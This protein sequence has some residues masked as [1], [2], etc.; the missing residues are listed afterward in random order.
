MDAFR[1]ISGI[2]VPMI[3]DNIDTDIIFPARFLLIMERKGLGRYLFYDRRFTRS[4]EPRGDSIIDA[5][6]YAG[7]QILIAGA[8]F[9]C[10]SSREQAVWALAGFGIRAVIAPG[11]GEIFFANCFM[12]GVLPIALP[13]DIVTAFA[14]RAAEGAVFDI[15]L[16]AQRI[17]AGDDLP[18]GFAIESGR[19]AALLRGWDEIDVILNQDLPAIER[20]EARHAAIQ[21][22]L[23]GSADGE[24]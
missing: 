21:P 6:A 10:G 17:V 20:F 11:F 9:G 23:F 1:R 3:E 14:R 22:W 12:S 4:G 18:I 13:Q 7:A 16:E 5:P 15:D 8:N 24:S 2:A 19:R